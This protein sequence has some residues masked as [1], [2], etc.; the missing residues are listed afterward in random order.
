M[1]V[2]EFEKFLMEINRTVRVYSFYPITHP[3]LQNVIS[4]MFPVVKNLLNKYEQLEF[5]VSRNGFIL[6][7]ELVLKGKEVYRSLAYEFLRRKI[8]KVFILKN[9]TETEL[10]PLFT[11][12]ATEPDSLENAGGVENMLKDYRVQNLWI[13]SIDFSLRKE[14][15]EKG[16]PIA[17]SDFFNLPKAESPDAQ[18]LTMLLGEI[19]EKIDTDEFSKVLMEMR[20]LSLNLIELNQ[21]KNILP[22]LEVL[23]HLSESMYISDEKREFAKK[24]LLSL[25]NKKPGS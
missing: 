14:I 12:L 25:V 17:I 1:E 18:R 21:W 24:V 5:E 7:E 8:K 13:N 10:K 4:K 11:A 2:V 19:E 23:A 6:D 20:A 3:A 9:L 16:P 15:E 22:V